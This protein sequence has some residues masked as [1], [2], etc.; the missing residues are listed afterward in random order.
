MIE[1][2]A[3]LMKLRNL[4]SNDRIGHHIA[5]NIEQVD[6][7]VLVSYDDVIIGYVP[8]HECSTFYRLSMM[9]DV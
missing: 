8:I 4:A 1:K 7:L 5:I 3:A 2:M 6:N 9:V